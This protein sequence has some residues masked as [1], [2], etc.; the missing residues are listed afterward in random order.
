MQLNE[1]DFNELEAMGVDSNARMRESEFTKRLLPHLIPSESGDTNRR[2]DIYIAAVGHANRMI[3]VVSDNDPSKVLYV[4]PPLIS[5]TPMVI[6]SES[7][8]PDTSIGTLA[9]E[10]EVSITTQHPG[11]VIDQFVQRLVDLNYSPVDAIGA[12][13]AR[14]WASIY[15]R[16]NIPLERLFGDQAEAVRKELNLSG[17]VSKET[18]PITNDFDEEDFE[19]M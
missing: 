18:G 14:M 10:F 17:Q 1:N 3:E 6:R 5:Q 7:S 11:F 8:S 15:V 4:V 9:E 12:V 16:Y 19:P 2:V 13:Y